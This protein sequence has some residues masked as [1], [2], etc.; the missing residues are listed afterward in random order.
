MFGLGT[1]EVLIVFF[2]L[3]VVLLPM[4]LFIRTMSTTLR[5]TIGHHSAAPG[6]AWLMLVP[7]LNLGWQFYLVSSATK[8][9]KGR[10]KAMGMD[11]GDAGYGV[12]LATCVLSCVANAAQI[13]LKDNVGQPLS[14]L[15]A[16]VGLITAISYWV[17]IADFNR[18]MAG[19]TAGQQPPPLVAG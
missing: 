13:F 6:S 7:L 1:G 5:L 19:A 15:V 18:V 2:M 11:P 14:V 10:Y 16:V 12:G 4:V 17:K 9:I 3:F 8:G